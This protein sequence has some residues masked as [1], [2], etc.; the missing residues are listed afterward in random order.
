MFRKKTQQKTGSPIVPPS[1]PTKYPVGTFVET[2]KGYFYV[3]S[4]RRL[5]V[6]ERVLWSWRPHRVVPSSEAALVHLKVGGRLKFRNGTLIQDVSDQRVYL[7]EEAKKRPI[8]S[9]D[10]YALLGIKYD[11]RYNSIMPV[12]KEEAE[13][14]ELGSELR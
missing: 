2:E 7:I 13:M 6:S 4:T 11:E 8:V 1:S 5:K 12:S 10:A 14:H 9:P 3:Q